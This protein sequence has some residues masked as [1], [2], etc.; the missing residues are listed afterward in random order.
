MTKNEKRREWTLYF[1]VPLAIH[2]LLSALTLTEPFANGPLAHFS[3]RFSIAVVVTAVVA[4][5]ASVRR[6]AR[7]TTHRPAD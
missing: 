2:A 5:I 4:A 1:L 7:S 6:S 3:V